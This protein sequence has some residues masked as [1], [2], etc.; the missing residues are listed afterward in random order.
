[1][2]MRMQAYVSIEIEIPDKNCSELVGLIV[3]KNWMPNMPAP[4]STPSFLTS[5]TANKMELHQEYIVKV[6]SDCGGRFYV[7]RELSTQL[8]GECMA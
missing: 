4:K 8:D 5:Y 7:E 2:T 3:S 6:L 1:M